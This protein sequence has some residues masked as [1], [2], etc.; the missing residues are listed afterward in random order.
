VRREKQIVKDFYETYGWRR[1]H[2]NTYNDSALF[3]DNREVL[4]AYARR[5]HER[6][7]ALL[8]AEG[9][10]FLDAGCGAIP[11][12]GYLEYSAGFHRRV[13]VDVS[14]AALVEAR[15]K[16]GVRGLY[17]QADLTNL[18]L[19]S[20]VC[21]VVF[22]AHV[23]YH[24]PPDEQELAVR[25]LYRMLEPDGTCVIIYASSQSPLAHAVAGWSRFTPRRM[26]RKVA[27]VVSRHLGLP[28]LASSSRSKGM[29]GT[30]EPSRPPLFFHAH[31][32]DWFKQVAPPEWDVD[33][34]SLA[35]ADYEFTRAV[36][37]NNL[38][39]RL[40]LAAISVAERLF[41]HI[42][43]KLGGYPMIVIRR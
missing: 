5:T 40:M 6:V 30:T 38:I 34:R 9:H 20:G 27:R 31:E 25:E 26:L 16:L 8:K 39:G 42:T 10:F 4:Q 11:H 37:P 21:S 43:A 7:K 23:L 13:C 41:P 3:V 29:S 32:L 14:H 35:L 12:V 15:A 36:V 17:V 24:I 33:I 18:P 22:S 2:A 28:Q 19:K 1:D